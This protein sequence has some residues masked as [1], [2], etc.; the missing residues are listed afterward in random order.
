MDWERQE[1]GPGLAE[2]W[3]VAED[4]VTWTF[5]L[6]AGVRWSDGQ[7]LTADDV[8][9]TWNDIIYRP[10]LVSPEFDRIVTELFRPHG[11]NFAITKMDGVTVKVVTPEVYAPFL[12]YF[13]GVLILPQHSL[14]AAVRSRNLGPALSS[15]APPT[16]IVG[17]GPFQ[18]KQVVPEKFTLLERNP[19]YWVTD[20]TGRRLPYFE[21]VRFTVGGGAGTEELLFL[22]GKSDLCEQPRQELYEQFRAGS[23]TNKFLIHDLGAGIEQDF[24]WFNQNTGTNS[25]GKPFVSPDL[26]KWFANKKFRQALSGAVDREAIAHD[27]YRDRAKPTYNFIPSENKRWNNTNAPRYAFDLARARASLAEIGLDRTNSAGFLSGADGSAVEFKLFCN[28][29]NP[30]RLHTSERIVQDWKRLGLNVALEPLDFRELVRR[31]S[32]TFDYDCAIMGLSGGGIDP[33]SQLHVLKS[34]A[35][36]HQWFPFQK[37]PATS[38]EGRIDHLMDQQM[39]TLDFAQRKKMFNEIQMILAEEAP[40]IQTISQVHYSTARSSLA[41]LRPAVMVPYH[42][43]WNIEELYFKK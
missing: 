7:P 21:D 18:V 36:L 17:S 8:L 37:S 2:S 19:E 25:A 10:E 22:N 13:G 41:N 6:R 16:R 24:A 9:F 27:V 40:M 42:L 5:K 38:W 35:D 32:E 20:K 26:L 31:I 3:S 14:E 11:T 39:R 1:L 12:E 43:T 4:Q 28:L 23:A 33:A 34:S 29:G 15:H 30:A